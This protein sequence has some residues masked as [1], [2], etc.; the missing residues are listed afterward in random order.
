[1]S[2]RT[3]SRHVARDQQALRVAGA[4]ELG[5]AGQLAQGRQHLEGVVR[6]G[7]ADVE[8]GGLG[9]RGGEEA[10]LGRRELV[11]ELLERGTVHAGLRRWVSHRTSAWPRRWAAA[12][13]MTK[14]RSLRRLR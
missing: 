2:S 6:V 13:A 11:A 3:G 14:S 9:R 8:D 4:P 7:A 12:R 1:M 10:G 5:P